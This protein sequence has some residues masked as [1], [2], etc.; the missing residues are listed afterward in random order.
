MPKYDVYVS[1]M[2]AGYTSI[3]K[4]THGYFPCRKEYLGIFIAN[5]EQ[6]AIKMAEDLYHREG[7]FEADEVS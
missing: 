1:E 5:T 4:S 3:N 6:E 2:K 7:L